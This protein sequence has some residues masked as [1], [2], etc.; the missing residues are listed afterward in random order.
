MLYFPLF[1]SLFPEGENIPNIH[2][3]GNNSYSKG[4]CGSAVL[5]VPQLCSSSLASCTHPTP[6]VWPRSKVRAPCWSKVPEG[7][8]SQLGLHSPL[9]SAHLARG[10]RCS[11][12][13]PAMASL[14]QLGLQNWSNVSCFSTDHWHLRSGIYLWIVRKTRKRLG[15]SRPA[16][17]LVKKFSQGAAWFAWTSL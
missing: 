2:F 13:P 8:F 15:N 4:G 16:S 6:H 9:A 12:S 11:Q 10:T 17:S 1:K 5:T 7:P 3:T 14:D